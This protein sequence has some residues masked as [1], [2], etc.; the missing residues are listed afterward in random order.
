MSELFE[1]ETPNYAGATFPTPR[2]FQ[3]LAHHALRE[4]SRAS[5]RCQMFMCPTRK[6]MCKARDEPAPMAEAMSTALKRAL[7]ESHIES[8]PPEH[9]RHARAGF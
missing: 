9:G 8:L 5:H 6:G 4:G 3:E 1:R 2:D 7:P